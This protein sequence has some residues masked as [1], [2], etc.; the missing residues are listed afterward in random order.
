MLIRTLM[1]S[2]SVCVFAAS[3]ITA[4]AQPDLNQEAARLN[5]R[6]VA[7]MGQQL[8]ARAEGSFADAL[9]ANPKMA[10]AVI[11]RGIALMTL[12]KLDE[13]KR[14]FQRALVLDPHNPQA[15]YNLGLAQHVENDMEAALASFQQ[16]VKFDPHDADSW[17]FLGVCYGEL[18]QFD[19]EIEILQ[20]AL[21]INPLHASSEFAIARA[22]QRTSHAAEAREHF[23][24]FQ[25]LT[26]AKISSAIGLAYGEQGRYSIATTVREPQT[27]DHSMIPIKLV[28][29]PMIDEETNNA[30]TGGACMLDVTGSGQMD[31]VLMQSGPQAIR[32]LHR[33]A[34]GKFEDVDV[35]AAGL[36]AQGTAIACAV[37]DY[38]GD[39]LNDLAVAFDDRLLLF[40]NLG[41]GK[42][43]DVTREAALT[44]RNHPSGITFIDFDHDGDLDFFV[45][46]GAAQSG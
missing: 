13:A 32:V 43:Q 36:K 45:D 26:S 1:C 24:R 30:E 40:R 34:D 17:Y 20:H 5:N 25:H 12:Q 22:L 4:V 37:G 39:N 46:G 14:A 3:V 8:T 23:K 38:D 27:N 21:S 10:Q 42:F 31:L 15:W 9:K 41:R 19:K 33:S 29:Q 28:P 18:K 2:F 16:A 35:A 7:Q 11:N 6:G 44:L